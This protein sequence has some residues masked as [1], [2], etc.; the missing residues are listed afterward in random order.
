VIDAF[1]LPAL[2]HLSTTTWSY[3][4]GDAVVQLR[5][6]QLT[7]ALLRSQIDALIDTQVRH[8]EDRPIEGIVFA[9][10]RVAARFADPADPVRRLA[11]TALPAITGY[12]PAMVSTLLDVMAADWRAP[13]L[14]ELLREELGDPAVL[15]SFRARRAAPGLVRAFG[16]RLVTH[17]FSGNVPGV[18]VTSLIRSLLVKGAT[19]GKTAAGEP[20]LPTLF[21]RALAGE[22]AELGRCV[23]VT[24]WPGGN[25]ELEKVALSASEAVIVYGAGDAVAAVRARTPSEARFIGYDHKL[26][27]GVIGREALTGEQALD[28]AAAAAQ[29]VATFD[30]QGCVS[31]H[32]FYVEEGGELSPG[33][34]ARLLAAEMARVETEL[35]R[36]TLSPREA[37]AI[38]QLRG[39][40]EFAQLAETG[41]ELHASPEGTAWTVIFDPDPAFQASCL[42]RVVRVKPV[43]RIENVPL[44]VASMGRFLQTVGV[45]A[46]EARRFWLASQLGRSGAS[47]VTP[48]ASMAWPPPTWHHDGRP[49]LLDLVRWCDIEG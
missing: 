11:E 12:S 7:P 19:L 38:R 27:F 4:R 34:W 45:A 6:P 35:P 20:L 21:A 47:R 14:L 10:D 30:Q 42:N 18:G 44:L 43:S 32:L 5:I 9:I 13:R 40:A 31:P 3:G 23:A 49:A 29:A 2:P 28:A 15:D 39:E 36:G 8:L 26:S 46:G 41:V 33:E 22:D 37:S 48:I 24:Y 25:E 16:P 1:H 17:I